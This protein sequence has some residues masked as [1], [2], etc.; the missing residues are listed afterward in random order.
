MTTCFGLFY[1]KRDLVAKHV[2]IFYAENR[3]PCIVPL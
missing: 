3:V 2:L 1:D